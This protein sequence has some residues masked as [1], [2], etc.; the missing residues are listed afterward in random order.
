MIQNIVNYVK[1]SFNLGFFQVVLCYLITGYIN[2][3]RTRYTNLLLNVSGQE[4][5]NKPTTYNIHI[6]ITQPV[7]NP[8]HK[9]TFAVDKRYIALIFPSK[10]S[11]HL[12]FAMFFYF[13]PRYGISTYVYR[14]LDHFCVAINKNAAIFFYSGKNKIT[15]FAS[16]LYVTK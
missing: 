13:F 6:F 10:K 16:Q 9:Y 11:P 12:I 4:Q 14:V 15:P 7:Q 2:P 3:V 5:V 1:T 8:Y